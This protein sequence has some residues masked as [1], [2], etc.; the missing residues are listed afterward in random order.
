MHIEC[1]SCA[2]ENKIDHG[3]NIICSKC[4]S[5]FA[6]HTY[7]KFKKPLLS[8]TTAIVIGAYG[9][10]KIDKQFIEDP[11]YPINIEYELM[12]SCINSSRALLNSFQRSEKTRVCSC[13][14]AS[15]MEDVDIN[16][17]TKNETGFLSRF[18]RGITECY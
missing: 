9:A 11:R 4:K 16:E 15:T 8:A 17:M 2:T 7:K 5:T 13:A 12:D 10:Y 14:L 3:E 1:P 18:R 6:G